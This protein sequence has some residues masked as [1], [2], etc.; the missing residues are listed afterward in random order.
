MYIESCLEG[1]YFFSSP[2]A[3]ALDNAGTL[4]A[5]FPWSMIIGSMGRNWWYFYNGRSVS[6][7]NHASA[8]SSSRCTPCQSAALLIIA[9]KGIAA[10]K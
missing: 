8:Y 9:I 1:L 5:S 2:G 6:S 10:R 3:T 4:N 7:R